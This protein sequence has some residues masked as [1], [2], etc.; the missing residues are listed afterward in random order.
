MAQDAGRAGVN[1]PSDSL[2]VPFSAIDKRFEQAH[3][4]LS[5]QEVDRLSRFGRNAR[6]ARGES[7]LRTG[8]P[9]KVMYVIREGID[10]RPREAS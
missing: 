6:F 10:D 8:H 7:L 3:P 4:H 1:A 9:V 2:E 5:P